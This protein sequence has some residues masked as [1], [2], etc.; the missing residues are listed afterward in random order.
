MQISFVHENSGEP[1][2]LL[3]SD[4]PLQLSIVCWLASFAFLLYFR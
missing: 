1:S 4:R 3:L 2:R